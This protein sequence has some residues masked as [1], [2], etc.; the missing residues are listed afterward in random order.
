MKY[1]LRQSEELDIIDIA[2]TD[3]KENADDT[4]EVFNLMELALSLTEVDFTKLFHYN[5]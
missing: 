3:L 4:G 2:T 1:F 5:S